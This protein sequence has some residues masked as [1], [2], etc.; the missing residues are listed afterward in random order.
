MVS[1]SHGGDNTGKLQE[2]LD[3]ARKRF[4]L[5]GFERTTMNDIASH[6]S[7]SKGSLYYYFPDKQSLFKAVIEQEQEEFF[8]EMRKR[9]KI[10]KTPE[11]MLRDFIGIRH[12]H[13]K[14]FLNL[15]IFRFADFQKIKPHI[16]ETFT[17]FLA[18]ETRVIESIIQKGVGSG[19]FH[20]PDPAAMAALFLDILQGLRM[21]VMQHRDYME[22]TTE[23]Y[24]LI[25]ARHREFVELFIQVLMK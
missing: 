3:E 16:K 17:I 10:L 18:K 6:V 4:T 5:F 7:M 20:C 21:V 19:D 8:S 1:I 24:N 15:N 11:I 22:L 2:I 23:D 14:T 13:F 12:E 9:L 25:E